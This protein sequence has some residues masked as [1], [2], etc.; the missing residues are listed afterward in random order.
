MVPPGKKHPDG[1]HKR[2]DDQYAHHQQQRWLHADR[3]Q[4]HSPWQDKSATIQDA[5][6][7]A[8]IKAYILDGIVRKASPSLSTAKTGIY[9]DHLNTTDAWTD[10]KRFPL[11]HRFGT[12][13]DG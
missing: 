6:L 12:S 10:R 3:L 8:T 11:P 5:E 2:A 4:Y 7:A 13:S 9:S 1:S